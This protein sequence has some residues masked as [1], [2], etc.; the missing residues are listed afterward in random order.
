MRSD[1]SGDDQPGLTSHYAQRVADGVDLPSWAAGTF[2]PA[3]LAV[4]GAIRDAAY[5]SADN[6]CLL[7]IGEIARLVEVNPR[8]AVRAITVAL[9][10]GLIERNGSNLVNR[11][12][13]YKVG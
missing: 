9:A 6:T 7:S 8:I 12:I 10:A 1:S 4:L 11:G 5:K 2:N 3:E 13:H